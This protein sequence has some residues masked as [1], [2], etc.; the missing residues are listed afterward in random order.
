MNH[1]LRSLITIRTL[2][3]SSICLKLR[4][5]TPL[6]NQRG[7]Q[8]PRTNEQSSKNRFA[9]K[10]DT[11]QEFTKHSNPKYGSKHGGANRH[12]PHKDKRPM[13][14]EIEGFTPKAKNAL[15]SIIEE[16]KS[17]LSNYKVQFVNRG[18]LEQKHLALIVNGLD[19]EKQGIQLIPNNEGQL[20]VKQVALLDMVKSYSD[21]LAKETEQRLLEQ[22]SKS[23]LKAMHQRERADKKKSATKI[24]TLNWNISLG[25][26]R[27]QKK[28]EINKRINK[29]EKFLIYIDGRRTNNRQAME[30]LTKMADMPATHN[31]FESTELD[32]IELRRRNLILDELDHILE[33]TETKFD[34]SGS[35]DRL[36]ILTCA[37]K[38]KPVD[39]GSSAQDDKKQKRVEKQ[40]QKEQK[41]LQKVD[42]EELDSLYLFKI[43]D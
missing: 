14:F 2:C 17:H 25:D 31:S 29:G 24:V 21:K 43:E 11:R 26:L 30:T 38:D 12:H 16:V 28:V 23:A 36:L 10:F 3:Q 9:K 6:L 19:P 35:I 15:T 32:P 13:R 22:G 40:R 20:L 27:N 8:S 42:E 4:I 41:K 37:P 39:A 33:E 7:N 18:K 1:S 34:I 5:P